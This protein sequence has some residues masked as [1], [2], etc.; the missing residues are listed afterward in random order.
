MALASELQSTQVAMTSHTPEGACDDDCGCVSASSRLA[1][2]PAVALLP[3]IELRTGAEPIACTLQPD[4]MAGRMEDWRVLLSSVVRR[5]SLPDG[6]RLEFPRNV[7]VAEIAGLATAEQGFCSFFSFSITLDAAGV[8]LDV[9][10]PGDAQK[11]VSSLF[12]AT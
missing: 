11:L 2:S 1:G 7:D 4:A 3:T 12:G 10:A 8:V 9:R 6:V 5:S